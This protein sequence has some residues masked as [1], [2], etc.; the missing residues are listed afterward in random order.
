M[1]DLKIHHLIKSVIYYIIHYMI[2]IKL[3]IIMHVFHIFRNFGKEW[4]SSFQT[5]VMTSNSRLD[6]RRRIMPSYMLHSMC[7]T[8][9]LYYALF[10]LRHRY[11]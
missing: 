4:F 3:N 9:R 10:M 1:S 6:L 2:Y 8:Y 7:I 11:W 5:L